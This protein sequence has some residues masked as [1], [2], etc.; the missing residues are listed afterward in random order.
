MTASSKLEVHTKLTES[1]DFW[2]GAEWAVRQFEG[3]AHDLSDI[4]DGYIE[5]RKSGK[6]GG[7][8]ISPEMAKD[9]AGKFHERS[10][11]VFM[12]AEHVTEQI[13]ASRSALSEEQRQP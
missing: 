7:R 8:R 9:F 6:M 4:R 5:A 12:T 13:A 2:R 11:A 3:E 10:D 1:A